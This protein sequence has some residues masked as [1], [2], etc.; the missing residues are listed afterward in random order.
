MKSILKDM[1]GFAKLCSKGEKTMVNSKKQDPG[2][3]EFN[4]NSN[5][6]LRKEFWDMEDSI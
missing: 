4:Y 5:Y 3:G 6:T 1:N 2:I